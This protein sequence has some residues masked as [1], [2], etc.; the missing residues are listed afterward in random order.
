MRQINLIDEEKPEL[1]EV[2]TPV[3]KSF[4]DSLVKKTGEEQNGVISA[5][6]TCKMMMKSVGS[7]YK[8]YSTGKPHIYPYVASY[9]DLLCEAQEVRLIGD[10]DKKDKVY[11]PRV[12]VNQH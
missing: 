9:L 5:V 11:E 2:L 8:E 6:E 12:K 7:N 10:Y 3:E 1:F 4:I